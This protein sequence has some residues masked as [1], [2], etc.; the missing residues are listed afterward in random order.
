MSSDQGDQWVQQRETKDGNRNGKSC[1]LAT[2]H[3]FSFS[4]DMIVYSKTGTY[5]LKRNLTRVA[6]F[7]TYDEHAQCNEVDPQWRL[8]TIKVSH[9][10]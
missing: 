1:T 8:A 4:F 3:V 7:L 2:P 10:V 5:V 6:N 9:I